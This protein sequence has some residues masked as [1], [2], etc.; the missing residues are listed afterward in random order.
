MGEKQNNLVWDI[1]IYFIL[2]KIGKEI[3]TVSKVYALRQD[4]NNLGLSSAMLGTR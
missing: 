2:T 3:F 1:A 4:T